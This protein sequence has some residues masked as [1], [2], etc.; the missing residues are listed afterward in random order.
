MAKMATDGDGAGNTVQPRR[1]E[2]I[3]WIITLNNPTNFEK[4]HMATMA[5][6]YCVKYR[7]QMETGENGTPHI[8]GYLHLK[9]K[10]RL[11]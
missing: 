6:E 4:E 10:T 5:T 9:N 7:M 2:G 3:H 8:Q 1:P 11:S